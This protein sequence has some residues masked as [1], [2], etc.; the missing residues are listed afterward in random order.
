MLAAHAAYWVWLA[1]ANATVATL[2][3]DTLPSNWTELRR[4]WEYTHAARAVLQLIALGTLVF[5]VLL[6]IPAVAGT[7][8]SA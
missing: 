3:A 4:Q 6:E 2:T 7:K 5:S 8:R 1:P